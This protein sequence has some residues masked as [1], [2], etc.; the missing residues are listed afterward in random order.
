MPVIAPEFPNQSKWINTSFPLS[1][2]SL[3]GQPILLCFWT[4]CSVN[5]INII[6]ELKRIENEFT[7]RG[8]VIVSIHQPKFQH[9]FNFINIGLLIFF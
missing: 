6:E 8:L 7:K 2:E 1:L 4:F 5:S 3:K 9:E